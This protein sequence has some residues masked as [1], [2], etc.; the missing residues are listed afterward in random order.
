[1]PGKRDAAASARQRSTP[2]QRRWIRATH[3]T[4]PRD[5]VG[6]DGTGSQQGGRPTRKER[7][8]FKDQ[9][10]QNV[11]AE[12]TSDPKVDHAAIAVTANEVGTVTL[13]G[14]GGSFREKREASDAAKRVHGVTDV[15]NQLD[16]R[17]LMGDQRTD[18]DL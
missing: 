14:T 4:A 7:N 2:S 18:A 1:T 15:D 5:A 3:F 6:L 13:R 17:L 16:V 8:V 11:T 12:L 10:Q 9:L